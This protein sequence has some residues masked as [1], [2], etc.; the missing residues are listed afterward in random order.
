MLVFNTFLV[1]TYILKAQSAMLTPIYVASF[2][3]YLLLKGTS[4]VLLQGDLKKKENQEFIWCL[5]PSR[6][7][8]LQ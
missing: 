7:F 3:L 6:L 8:L 4:E 5:E 1:K 2:L